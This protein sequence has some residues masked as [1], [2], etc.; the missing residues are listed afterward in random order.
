MDR[1]RLVQALTETYGRTLVVEQDGRG[2]YVGVGHRLTPDMGITRGTTITSLEC[3]QFLYHD[4]EV[5]W[6]LV[7]SCW[8]DQAAAFPEIIQ[9]ALALLA[10]EIGPSLRNATS[11]L[12]TIER[13]AWQ[14]AAETLKHTKWAHARWDRAQTLVARLQAA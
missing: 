9:Q 11:F 4:I 2:L 5:A 12:A 8:P 1:R 10:W 3:E 7:L 13:H 6:Q 14:E